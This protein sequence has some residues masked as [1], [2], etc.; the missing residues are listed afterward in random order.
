MFWVWVWGGFRGGG[1]ADL[2][3]G[4]A[5]DGSECGLGGAGGGIDVGL[6]G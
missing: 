1:C 6:E 5:G 2:V 4:A 3:G